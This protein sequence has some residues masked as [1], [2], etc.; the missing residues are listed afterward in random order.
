MLNASKAREKTNMIIK[1][2]Y[3]SE[4]HKI[5]RIIDEATKH[6][7]FSI[8]RSGYLKSESEKKLKELGYK[9]YIDIQSDKPSYTISWK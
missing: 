8:S 2:K 9:V 3:P 7:Y 1:E 4:L 6:G 5:C